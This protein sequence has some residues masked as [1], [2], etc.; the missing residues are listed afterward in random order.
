MSVTKTSVVEET[1]IPST[2]VK[3]SFGTRVGAHF[4]KWWWV[5]LIIFV[6]SVLVISLPV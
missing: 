6:L 5:H 1:G 4:K 3:Q 2:P